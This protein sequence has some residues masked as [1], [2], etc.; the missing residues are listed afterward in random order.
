MYATLII[1]R[2]DGSQ[3]FHDAQDYRNFTEALSYLPGDDEFHCQGC[4]AVAERFQMLPFK[5]VVRIRIYEGDADS[6]G[7]YIC[8]CYDCHLCLR[9]SL[10]G[11]QTRYTKCP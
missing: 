4:V 11:Q 2:I 1:R 5:A 6:I 7:S 8:R 10:R 3:L 9:Y